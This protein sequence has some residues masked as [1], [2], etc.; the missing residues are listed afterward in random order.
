MEFRSITIEAA[1]HELNKS[2]FLPAIQR[3]FR[4]GHQRIEKLFDSLMLDFPIGSF[5][6]WNVGR[7]EARESWT[8]YKFICDYDEG[9]PHNPEATLLG[10]DSNI[11]LV[12]DGQQRLTAFYIGLQGSYKYFRWKWRQTKL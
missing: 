2:Y 6:F 9:N 8:I 5:L 10:A 7:D 4:W 1:I 12:L 3:E 11:E